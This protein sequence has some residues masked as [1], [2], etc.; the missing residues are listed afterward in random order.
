MIEG[1]LSRRY[2]KALFQLAVAENREDAVAGELAQFAEV[3]A[4]P[5]LNHVLNDPA[6]SR[7]RRKNVVAEIARALQLSSLL[8]HFL[9][10]LVER[11]RV[12]FLPGI[13]ERYRRMLDEK[14]GQAE[15]RVVAANPLDDG[16]LQRLRESLEKISGKKI[17]VQQESDASLI[18]G[19]V[20]QLEGKIYDGS[21]RTQLEKMKKQVEESY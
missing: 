19:V 4:Q 12:S 21:V 5:E 14:K 10:L 17:I 7:Q 18:G 13:V 20:V 8:T 16:D 15:A 3:F 6:F 9:E 2:A 1:S 11:D